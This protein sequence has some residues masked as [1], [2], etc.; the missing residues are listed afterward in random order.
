MTSL[1]Q[2]RCR[3]CGIVKSLDE[4]HR[5][6]S[7]K[8]GRRYECKPCHV[9][10]V[11]AYEIANRSKVNASGRRWRAANRDRINA[12]LR[13]YNRARYWK[14]PE[15][16]R[17]RHRDW[18]RANAEKGHAAYRRWVEGN[19]ERR[20]AIDREFY[21]RHTEERK[22]H[23]REWQERNR[24]KVKGYRYER[25]AKVKGIVSERVDPTEIYERDKGICHICKR[26]VSRK[27]F[28]LDHLIPLSKGGPHAASNV[29]VAH[30][31]CN[32]RRSDGRLPAQLR[33][34]G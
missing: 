16:A 23:V 2:K 13:E 4:F 24:D 5:N 31:R 11:K 15:A 7:A 22:Q 6:S 27:T 12:R 30:H 33:L 14:D 34:V 26:K 3:L 19:R 20:R 32:C 10:E 8:D 9:K 25:R 18:W 29:A 17:K 21:R 28:T 1:P